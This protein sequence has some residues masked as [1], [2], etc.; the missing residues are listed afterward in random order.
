ML[1]CETVAAGLLGMTGPMLATWMV[2]LSGGVNVGGIRPC[3]LQA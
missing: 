3:S 2:S 1:I